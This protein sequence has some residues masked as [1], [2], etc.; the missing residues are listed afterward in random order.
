MR[1]FWVFFLLT[2]LP[3]LLLAHQGGGLCLVR[4]EGQFPENVKFR[5]EIPG[6]QLYFENEGFTWHFY[7]L[8]AVHDLHNGKSNVRVE[9]IPAH[10]IRQKFLG[11]NNQTLVSGNNERPD[12][13]NYYLGKDPSGWKTGV[14]HYRELTYSQLYSNID[15]KLYSTSEGM[16]YDY[17]V[18]P[19]GDPKE[20]KLAYEGA[21]E[22]FLDEGALIVRNSI[23]TTKEAAPVA[24]QIK[25]GNKFPVPCTFTLDNGIVG[26]DFPEGYDVS[27]P[28]VIDPVLVFATYTGSTSDNWGY[29][30]TYD[31]T[32]NLYAGGI[33]F[34]F[35]YPVTTGAYQINFAGGSGFFPTDVAISK[36]SP[37]GTTLI[38]ST[39][40]GGS[41]NELP[42]SLVVNNQDELVVFGTTG[43]SDF[44]VTNG[45]F[46]NS[47]NGG[48][49]L[50]V[51]F[52]VDFSSGADQFLA[53]FNSAGT[54][55]NGC[56][57]VGGIGS[58]GLN[59]GSSLSANYGD[60]ARGEVITDYQGNIYVASSTES[61][62]FPVSSGC[63]QPVLAGSQEGCIYK[64]NS[65][66]SVMLWGT[67]LGGSQADAAY[68][69]AVDP[70]FNVL[71]TGGTLSSD[72]PM[73]VGGYDASFNSTGN[74]PD[75]FVARLDA[76]GTTLLDATF[77]GTGDYDQSYFTDVDYDGRVYVYGQTQDPTNFPVSSGVYTNPNSGQFITCFDA[78]LSAIQFS[79]VFGTGSGSI[80]ISPTAFLVDNC[81]H[82]YIAGWG[83]L[84]N[85]FGGGTTGLPLTSNAYQSTT[86][87]S[88]LYLMVLD[89]D[90]TALVYATF[91]GGSTSLEHVDGGTCRF[92]K[93]GVIYHAVCA[94]CGGNSDFPTT[95][96]V[97]STTN[98]ASNCNLAAFRF[99]FEPNLV[100]ADFQVQPSAI[101]CTT[102][103]TFT[104]T[105][106]S[107]NGTGYSW[108]FGDLNTSTQAN[109]THTYVNPGTY[110]I[111]L[112]TENLSSCNLYDTTYQTVYVRTPPAVDA[113]LPL[114]TC[115]GS[116][117]QLNASSPGSVA[118]SWS[119]AGS[120]TNGNIL[121][122]FASPAV[123]TLYTL[124]VTDSFGCTATDTVSVFINNAIAS[125]SPD[126]IVCPGDT[127]TLWAAGGNSYSW[128][129]SNGTVFTPNQSQTQV[130]P[131]FGTSFYTVIVSNSAGCVDSVTVQIDVNA[132]LTLSVP[133]AGPI[134]EGDTV[135]LN[136]I[137]QNGSPLYQYSWTPS[138]FLS[139][140]LVS[141]PLAFPATSTTFYL[142]TTDACGTVLNDSVFIE[143]FIRPVLNLTVNPDS[144]CPGNSVTISLATPPSPG[145]LTAW[146]FG[147]A[148][149][150]SGSGPGPYLVS[151][152]SGGT[153]FVG[154]SGSN[155]GCAGPLDSV[156]VFV[157]PPL[158]VFI[159]NDTTICPGGTVQLNASVTGGN[160]SPVQYSWAPSGFVQN[161][162]NQN[163]IGNPPGNTEYIVTAT[164]GCNQPDSDSLLVTLFSGITVTGNGPFTICEGDT[165]ILGATVSGGNGGPYFFLW[166]PA[167]GVSDPFL[168][169]PQFTDT[170]SSGF[171]VTVTD[172]CGF[173]ASDSVFVTVHPRPEAPLAQGDT[174]CDGSQAILTATAGFGLQIHWLDSNGTTV[175]QGNSYTIPNLTNAT[176][177]FA[178]AVDYYG[179][180]SYP[181]VANAS[182]F[183][184]PEVDFLASTTSTEIPYAIVTFDGQVQTQALI[185]SY[186]WEFGDGFTD[187]YEDPVHQYS[188]E[189]LYSV[190][191]RVVDE[192]GCIGEKYKPD[193]IAVGKD[194]RMVV[195][196]VFSPN[197]DGVNDAFW[198]SHRLVKDFHIYIF[199]RWGNLLYENRDLNFRWN[200]YHLGSPLP[201]GVYTYLIKATAVEGTPLEKSGT[202]TII[203]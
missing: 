107:T 71:V 21:Q 38:Y 14:K 53:K 18:E 78:N 44:P 153:Y 162:G 147:S 116:P 61:S 145:V 81:K 42:H 99:D 93:K 150:I 171:E 157:F 91:L 90:A 137:L 195:P 36:F 117:V 83:G 114:T 202:V 57:Y 17:L 9:N 186:Y 170:L 141:N 188:N 30:A 192:H 110:T 165:L 102:P 179:C 187:D 16:K 66:L 151:F 106:L 7:D 112:I 63:A 193:Y 4:N 135:S 98:N 144:V 138:Q 87:G 200:G 104:F 94:G 197:G 25:D 129:G 97:W 175:Y 34:N 189:G 156:E 201:E 196:N 126:T 177:Y 198:L 125:A 169:N 24:W 3:G 159:G 40:L 163:T 64:M 167:S 131:N 89:V 11:A 52:V 43:S 109:P 45:C 155:N 69:I 47:F 119:P 190:L 56:T 70:Q 84:T 121:N 124:T 85:S 49:A 23:Q 73:P 105:N 140:S 10:V 50:T 92:D 67:F 46:D 127:V 33:I 55:L 149:V 158:E 32:G 65:N 82:I 1:K 48:P 133:G 86:N 12:F 185:A 79:T 59:V 54:A 152:L 194:I 160:G 5:T 182:I 184:L 181:V 13:S 77:L 88:D 143:V 51:T 6:G 58:D 72:F 103:Y 95:T 20:I 123:N 118:F 172:G 168:Q 19:G 178:I 154:V 39:Y 62:D 29:T 75:A 183:P 146:N 22:I 115:T 108:D 199:D 161:P 101:I 96:G 176:I 142:T 164:D 122:P 130:L 111:T 35:G 31:Q 76:N 139:N 15:L 166:S 180:K 41:G 27:I 173:S 80:D 174:V 203:H 2:S 136:A 28:L 100:I 74:S 134:C 132:P 120:L 37:D 113:G 8:S 60:H 128:N 68:G 26:F 148:Q 191:F